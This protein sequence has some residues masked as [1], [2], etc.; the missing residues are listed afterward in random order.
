[1]TQSNNNSPFF[2]HSN[3]NNNN[4][5]SNFNDNNDEES[6]KNWRDL[7]EFV[8]SVLAPTTTMAAASGANTKQQ[9]FIGLP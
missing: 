3:N 4:N 2:N 1:L 9:K 5:P 6:I 7:L 8:G